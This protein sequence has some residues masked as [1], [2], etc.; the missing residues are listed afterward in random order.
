MM[1]SI[2]SEVLELSCPR[3]RWAVGRWIMADHDAIT[4]RSEAQCMY[5]VHP[6]CE[7]RHDEIKDLTRLILSDNGSTRYSSVAM[8]DFAGEVECL[9]KILARIVRTP[10]CTLLE[11]ELPSAVH[12]PARIVQIYL[13]TSS[14]TI[15]SLSLTTCSTVLESPE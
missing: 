1:I 13:R 14:T 9:D 2:K 6:E 15:A 7:C 3:L 10:V 5:L 11:G 8:C 4:L 12:Q